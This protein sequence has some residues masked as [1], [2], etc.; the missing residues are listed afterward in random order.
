MS[1]NTIKQIVGSKLVIFNKKIIKI[2]V[3]KNSVSAR[4]VCV[5]DR[6]EGG[7]KEAARATTIVYQCSVRGLFNG[8][9]EGRE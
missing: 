1:L 2:I 7:R 4:C 3:T 6:K 9:E 5:L 8:K